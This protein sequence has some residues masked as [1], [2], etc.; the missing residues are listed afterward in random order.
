[1]TLSLAILLGYRYILFSIYGSP[2]LLKTSTP[3]AALSTSDVVSNVNSKDEGTQMASE[4]EVSEVPIFL[5][6]SKVKVVLS[7]KNGAIQEIFLKEFKESD[8][9]YQ[10]IKVDESNNLIGHLWFKNPKL[11]KISYTT[12]EHNS[13]KVLFQA[14][15]Q[16]GLILEKSMELGEEDYTLNLLLTFKNRTMQS[17]PLYYQLTAASS[18]KEHEKRFLEA[19]TFT[20]GKRKIFHLNNVNK[21]AVAGETKTAWVALKEKYFSLIVKPESEFSS[22]VVEPAENGK[23]L[24]LKVWAVPQDISAG[25]ELT[26][27]Y[28][29][30]FG[31]NRLKELKKLG[32]W[33][34]QTLHYGM[35]SGI[36]KFL[37]W[38]LTHIYLVVKN[39][40]LAIII[41]TVFVSVFLLPLSGISYNSMKKMKLLQ[42][43]VE[44]IR[45]AYRDKPQKLNKEL[46]DLY[47]RNKVNPL[48]GCLPMLIQM[49]IFIAFYNALIHSIEL[50]GAS[51]F[52]IK[53]LSSPD[54][55]IPLPFQLGPFGNAI[56]ILPILMAVA[57]SVQQRL[58]TP[59]AGSGSDA[60]A[61]RTMAM[62]M[63]FLFGFIFYGLPSG[64]V[65]YWLTNN[66]VMIFTQKILFSR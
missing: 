8:N 64:L 56:N 5:E 37:L 63:P 59:L 3:E 6:N 14:L 16:N 43:E 11:N 10:L 53:D 29:F 65:L 60:E 55:A 13:H 23:N 46:M 27:R 40:G 52:F 45:E 57:M 61:Q 30:Y 21:G 39:Y 7:P 47:R 51:F 34:E 9:P 22:F 50:K 42:P 1:M 32:P 12:V 58:N 20:N 2:K 62:M 33:A 4:G 18:L 41:L 17:F 31:P 48:G 19:I 35:F 49:P 44:K 28:L 24:A 26:E 25:E 38:A 54:R 15:L 66:I 36:T